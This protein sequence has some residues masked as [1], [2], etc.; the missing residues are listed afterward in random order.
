MVSISTYIT[1]FSVGGIKNLK[2][3]VS[4]QFYKKTLDKKINLQNTNIKAIYGC[5]G[6]WKSAV[7][8][9]LKIYTD[10]IKHK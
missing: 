2:E 7:I 5:N 1:N 4:L 8:H 6:A 10:T 3:K 9:A